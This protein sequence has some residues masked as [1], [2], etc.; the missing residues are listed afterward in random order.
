MRGWHQGAVQ[1]PTLIIHGT[2][3]R[4]VACS[5]GRLL[6]ARLPRPAAPLWLEGFGH[7]D[8]DGS[9][10]YFER[11]REFVEELR[12]GMPAVADPRP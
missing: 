4:V 10:A 6:H 7:N 1:C 3:D 8:L 11:L 2:A 9:P 5:H 12:R